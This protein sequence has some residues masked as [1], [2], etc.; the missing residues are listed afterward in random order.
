MHYNENSSR[1]QAKTSD[2]KLR[3]SVSYPKAFKGEKPVAKPL[4]EKPTYGKYSIL[5]I[6]IFPSRNLGIR[7]NITT[8]PNT[9]VI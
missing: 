2:G 4:K 3:W 5:L 9:M 6:Q 8:I 1:K 7:V